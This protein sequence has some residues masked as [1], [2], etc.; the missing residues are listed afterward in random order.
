V[1]NAI[2][3]SPAQPHDRDDIVRLWNLCGLVRHYNPPDR[4]FDFA[5]GRDG[6]DILV[7]RRDGEVIGAVMVGHDGHR[8]WIYYLAV[9]PDHQHN[10]YGGELVR[11]AEAWL[12]DR[13]VR[14]CQLMVRETNLDVVNFYERLGYERS[15]VTVMQRWLD[16]TE[17]S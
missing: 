13:H 7:L 1:D 14:K 5:R 17:I 9:N 6:S 15:P 8:G 10:G 12:I 3:I 4:D 2:A 16:G 11:A